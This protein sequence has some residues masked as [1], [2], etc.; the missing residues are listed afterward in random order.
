MKLSISDRLALVREYKAQGGKG[1]Y[2]GVIKEYEKGGFT[3]DNPISLPGGNRNINTNRPVIT[4]REEFEQQQAE[5]R[6]QSELFEYIQ[7]NN[8]IQKAK[9][10][11]YTDPQT[12]KQVIQNI[13]VKPTISPIDLAVAAVAAGAVG[14]VKMLGQLAELANPLPKLNPFAFKASKDMMYRG[15]GEAGYKDAI[16]SGVFR[17]KQYANLPELEANQ[18]RS[19]LTQKTFNKTYYAPG[20]RFDVIKGYDPAYIAEVPKDASDFYKR[21]SNKNWSQ[22]TTEQI[23]IEKGKIYKQHWLQGYKEVPKKSSFASGGIIKDNKIKQFKS[24]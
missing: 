12:G 13:G 16:E 3:E 10:D 17:P 23:P 1:H 14:G 4:P 22:L 15:L 6:K 5:K 18:A 11:I 20:E 8:E 2:L 21:Y 9:S 24:K 19:I 7:R